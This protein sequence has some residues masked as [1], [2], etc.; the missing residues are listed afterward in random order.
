VASGV[1]GTM[2]EKTRREIILRRP[3]RGYEPERRVVELRSDP[4]LGIPSRISIERAAR[5]KTRVSEVQ[6]EEECPFLPGRI[7]SETPLFPSDLFPREGDI[8]IPQ[9]YL[10][11]NSLL[12]FSTNVIY[13]SPCSPLS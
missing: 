1:R 7:E 13:S 12:C 9:Q 4:L 10:A 2:F 8:E 3:L 5:P 6:V 11:R